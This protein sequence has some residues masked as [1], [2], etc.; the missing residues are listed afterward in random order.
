M[1]FDYENMTKLVQMMAWLCRGYRNKS[2]EKH[3]EGM[4]MNGEEII[5]LPDT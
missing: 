5:F 2:E 3:H 4:S 1:F